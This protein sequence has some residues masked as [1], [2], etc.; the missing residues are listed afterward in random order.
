MEER[1]SFIFYRSF[2]EAIN[3]LPKENQLEI[4]KAICE[5]SLNF[6][7]IELSGISKTIFKLIRPQL[8][9]NNTK[10][11]N[12]KKGGPPKGNQNA[13]KKQPKNNAMKM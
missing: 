9:A 7:D 13:T 6:K 11:F 1:N 12:G 5:L 10:Y 8:D 3:D 4:Y 2:Y